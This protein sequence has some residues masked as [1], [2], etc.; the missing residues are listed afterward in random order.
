MQ[1]GGE[2][3]ENAD[4]VAQQHWQ[5]SKKQIFEISAQMSITQTE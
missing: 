5:S 3:N 1:Q 4:T 2:T